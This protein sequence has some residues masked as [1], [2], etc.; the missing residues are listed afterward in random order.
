MHG[1]TMKAR[2]LGWLA[3]GCGFWSLLT[4]AA[5]SSLTVFGPERFVPLVNATAHSRVFARPALAAAACTLS[6]QNGDSERTRVRQGAITLNRSVVMG[7]TDFQAALATVAKPVSLQ[8]QNTLTVALTAS[9]GGFVILTIRCPALNAA[10]LA[11]A[12]ADQTAPVGA[13]LALDGSGTTDSDGDPL[14]YLWSVISRPAGSTATLSDPTALQPLFMLDQAGNYVLQLIVN[15]GRLASLPDRV[16]LSTVNSAPVAQAG[17]SQTA[18]PGATVRLDGSGA[19]DVDGDLLSYRWTLTK[20]AGSAAVLSA[21]SAVQPSL[22]ID[23]PGVYTAQLLVNDGTLTSA[24]ATTTISTGNTA[25]IANAGPDQAITLGAQPTLDGSAS[26]DSNGD[27]LTYRWSLLSVPTGSSATLSEP[28]TVRPRLLIDVPGVY[29]A[30]LLVNDGQSNSRPDTVL[31]TTDNARPVAILGA[32]PTRALGETITLDGAAS[33]DAEGQALRYRWAFTARPTGSSAA[34]KN[35]TTARPSFVPDVVGLYVAQLIVNDG[36]LDSEPVTTPIPVIVINHP[37]TIL[38]TPPT[39]AT[40]GQL[41]RYAL[42]AKDPDPGTTLSYSLTTKP[43]GMTITATGVI[44]WTPTTLGGANVVVRVQDPAGLFVTQSVTITVAA[45]P[46]NNAPTVE[47][48]NAQ[49]IVLPTQSVTLNSTVTDDGH[50]NPPG[51]IQV[52]WSKVSG[53]GTVTFSTPN[54]KTTT[55]TCST[56]GLYSLKLTA[57]DGEKSAS[58]TV[59]IT[60]NPE[61]QI[62]LPPDPTTVAPKIDPTVATTTHAATQFLYTG[63]NPIQTGVAPG[64]IEPKRAAVL[65]GKVLDKQNNP[66]PGV[67]ISILNHPEFGQTRSRA[68][69]WFDLA[70]N[71]GGYLTLNYQKNDY[72]PAQRQQNVPWQDFV[73]MEDVVLITRDAQVT[74]VDLTNTTDIQIMRGSVVT[75]QDGTRQATLF[76]PPGTQAQ[77]YNPDGSLRSVTTLSLRATEYTIG[78]NGPQTMPGLLP[79]NV[80]YT[81]AVEIGADEATIKKDGKDVLFDRPVSFYVD[82]FLNFPIG[83]VV[84][85]GYYNSSQSAWIP[86]DSGR[87]IKILSVNGNLAQ[88][89]VSGNGQAADTAALAAL[90][91][92]DAERAK[93]ATLYPVGK[94]L[95]RVA[96]THLSTWDC[97]WPYGPPKDARPPPQDTPNN[98]D[99]NNPDDC[100][101]PMCCLGGAHTA[102]GSVIGCENQNLG[103]DIPVV[104]TGVSLHY[105]SDRVSGRLSAR[106]LK[107]PLSGATIPASLKR[108]EANVQVAGLNLNLGNFPAQTAQATTFTWDGN[109]AYGQAMQGAQPVT[110]KIGYVYDGT[111]QKASRFGQSSGVTITGNR[112]RQEITLWRSVQLNVNDA[113]GLKQA[114]IAAWGL[115]MHHVYDPIGQILYQGDGARRRALGVDKIITT[116]AGVGPT[117]NSQG[118][119]GLATQAF[120]RPSRFA[121]AADGSVFVSETSLYVRRIAPNGVITTFAGSENVTILGDGGP[122]TSAGLA[123]PRGLAIMPDG[124]ILIAESGRHRIR[125]VTPDGIISTFAGSGVRGLGGDEGPALQAELNSPGGVAMMADGSVLIADSGNNRIRR[126]MPDGTMTRFAG[127]SGPGNPGASG[128][129]GPALLAAM[130]TPSGIAVAADGGV[131]IA[132]INNSRIRR[133]GPDGIITTLAGNGNRSSSGDGGPATQA[134]V[135]QPEDVTVDADGGILIAEPASHRIRRIGPD[136]IIRTIAGTGRNYY[137]GDGG[138]ALQ[139]GLYSPSGVAVMGDGSILVADN[140]NFRIRKISSSVPGFTGTDIAI[141]SRDGHQIYRFN[142][143]GRHLSTVDALTGATLYT[144]AYDS[145]GRLIKIT[146]TDSNV[147]TIERDG[148]GNPTALVAP[149]GQRTTLTVDGNGYLASVINPAGEAYRMQYTADGLLTRFT[150]PRNNASQFTYDN[151]GRLQKDTNAAGGSQ[152]LARTELGDSYTVTRTTALNRSTAYS[153]EDLS[154]GDRRRKVVTPDGLETQTLLGTNDSAKVTEPDGSITDSLDGPDPRFGMQSPITSSSKVT[155]GG[156]TATTTSSVTTDPAKPTD[157]LTFNTLTRTTVVN[158]RTATSVYDKATRK[159][160]VTS[161]AGRQSYSILDA[162]GR[163]IEAGVTGLEPIMMS[164]DG[165]GHLSS[166]TQGSG[167][168]AR[169]MTL[170][171]NADGYLQSATDALGHNGSLGYDAAGRVITQT[172][173]NGQQIQ[174]GYDAKGNLTSLTPPG[175]PTHRFTY[176]AVDLATSYLPPTVPGGGDTGYEYNADKQ[177]TKVTRPDGG[178]LSYAY[179]AAGRLGTLTIPVG[180]YGY[181]YNAAGQLGGIIAPSGVNLAYAYS[182]SLLT[183]VTWSGGISGSVGFGYD[184]DFRVKQVTVNGA[185][186]I[187]YQYDADSLLTQAGDL[188]FTRNAQNGLLTGTALGSVAD[189]YTYNSFGEPIAYTARYNATNLLDIAYTRDKLGRITQKVETIGGGVATTYNYGYDTIGQLTEVKRN[190]STVASYVYDANGNRLSK[191][192]GGNTVNGTYD[193]QDRML[194]YGNATYTYTANGELKTKVIGG[195]TTT[196]DYDALGDLRNVTLPGG[197]QITYLIDGKNRRVG[198]KV[199]GALVQGFLYQ[200]QLQPIAELDGNGA[201]VSRFIYGKGINVPDYLVKGGVTYRIVT[202]HLGS[203]R[204][205]VNTTTGAIAQQ[206]D[207]DEYGNVLTDTSPGFQPFGFAGGLYD[208]DTGLVRFGARDYEAESGRWMVKD[209]KK[210][211]S[212]DTNIYRYVGNGVMNFMDFNGFDRESAQEQIKKDSGLLWKVV[213]IPSKVIDTVSDT[214][215]VIKDAYNNGEDPNQ[216]ILKNL[217]EQNEDLSRENKKLRNENDAKD[218][219]SNDPEICRKAC[220]SIGPQSPLC[221]E[222]NN[223]EKRRHNGDKDCPNTN[224][225]R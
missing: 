223:K 114:N 207:Y 62:P 191:T 135:N 63:S 180:Q 76:I 40:V 130:H 108:I 64:T 47:A 30:Q 151:L 68:D 155:T 164:Y 52:V 124:S 41:Y 86:Y 109:N 186:P 77:V 38:S 49:T 53:P 112:T 46:P 83:S 208:R 156:L 35:A 87:I 216:E 33:R 59:T 173:A 183:G 188:A 128:D 61:P 37:P 31:L 201:I 139:A 120:L 121:V 6:V 194:S 105:R 54:A 153:V 167:A 212:G 125:R 163:T 178:V 184:T 181:S 65:R 140:L 171:Y 111:Y 69:G 145:D 204:L 132:E 97:N 170:A 45:A 192:T 177:L 150:D 196:Y 95:W 107:I 55:A 176:N 187:A 146:D 143:V 16:I 158:G 198:K 175:Q 43:A 84:P 110:V 154:T 85:I 185:N 206:M 182:G 166:L 133:V 98:G 197:T 157:P 224:Q 92:T 50:P 122:A 36:A 10:P 101:P 32:Q 104:G 51:T 90:G 210:F 115:D 99:D 72:L 174:F 56:A 15:D 116:F 79:A 138:P 3:L 203:P 172:L 23:V 225:A 219:C 152:S 100:P 159:T 179:D 147:I 13:I 162:T 29:V 103:E 94:S 218:I 119:G 71:G 161:A 14:R 1:R 88:L 217:R 70:V 117:G 25:P 209:K 148:N 5:D 190:G 81:Y 221:Q 144:F 193:A 21:P 222:S 202:D 189:S 126:V 39:T 82:N 18:A 129:G 134:Q 169:T 42:I 195:Q 96:L 137:G 22:A 58:D 149:F 91:I 142:A 7:A 12:G 57:S 106:T 205:V 26:R 118:D 74:T 19:S 9:P 44:D 20:P 136:G 200:G 73:V 123:N 213:K 220:D 113:L 66:L 131:L 78:S 60:V 48:G 141:A 2:W 17:L 27:R 11:Q 214:T 160:T 211:N 165:R 4:L 199:N 89:D 34:L 75:D 127:A 28:T 168:D 215:D 8:P 80:G 67:T 93:L 102:P 24:P